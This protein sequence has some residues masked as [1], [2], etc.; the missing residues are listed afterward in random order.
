[1][2][3]KVGNYVS[4]ILSRSGRQ[5][6]FGMYF[7]VWGVKYYV[8]NPRAIPGF[9]KRLESIARERSAMGPEDALP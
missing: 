2:E 8:S 6:L 7:A 3:W 4:A 5:S 1:M 9:E